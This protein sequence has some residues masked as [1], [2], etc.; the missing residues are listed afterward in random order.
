MMIAHKTSFSETPFLFEAGG[1]LDSIDVVYHTSEGEYT[2]GRRVIWVCHAL[3]ANS[4]VEEWWPEI[5]GPGK[6]IDPEK[7]YVVCVNMLC[8]AYGSMSA[9]SIN[10]ATGKP[11]FFDFPATTVRDM[12]S[13]SILVRK[14]LGIDHIDILIGSSIGGFQ[15][16]EWAVTEPDVIK[17]AIFIATAPRMSPWLG[18]TVATQR[19]ALEADQ[20]FRQCKDINGGANGLRCARAQALVSYR[21]YSGY[22]LTQSEDDPDCMFAGKVASYEKYQGDKFIKR[23]FDAYSYYYLCQALDS[24]NVGRNRGGVA[25]ALGTIKART[26]V[27]SIDTDVI[28]P[29]YELDQ[30]AQFIPDVEIVRMSSNYGHDGFLLETR[31]I[32]DILYRFRG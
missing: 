10:P 17:N 7:D 32:E 2:P 29:P 20:T 16:I 15:A 18:S 25:A 9:S 22:Q 12:I 6:A 14:K 30:W 8:S 27:A 19:M 23:K 4:N 21:C 13:A 28:F 26:L 11:F 5:A 3:T 31:Q 24:H 1:S